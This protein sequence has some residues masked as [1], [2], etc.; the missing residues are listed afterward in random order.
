MLESKEG[1]SM[2]ISILT[3][4]GQTTIPKD[5]RDH[6]RLRSNDKI[7]YVRDDGRVYIQTI[8]GNALDAAGAF[9]KAFRRPVDLK[10]LRE[11]TKS[12]IARSIVR[13]SQ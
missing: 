9:R 5:I 12:L 6:L 4:K 13:K 2:S 11:R 3:Q 10:K 8:K 1:R 7:V